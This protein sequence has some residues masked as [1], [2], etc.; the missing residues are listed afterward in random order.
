MKKKV[1]QQFLYFLKDNI[2]DDIEILVLESFELDLA[3]PEYYIKQKE[4]K[5]DV[6]KVMEEAIK[7]CER[8]LI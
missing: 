6:S 2:P 1:W 3:N 5:E 7:L 4:V 8:N